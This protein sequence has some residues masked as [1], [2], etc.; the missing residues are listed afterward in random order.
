MDGE[1]EDPLAAMARTNLFRA[2]ESRLNHK[3]QPAKVSPDTGKPAGCDHAGH[4]FDERAPRAGLDND[5][6]ER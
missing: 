6:P 1:H 5:A 3:T 4:V 2:E